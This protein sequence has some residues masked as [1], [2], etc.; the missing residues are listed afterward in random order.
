MVERCGMRGM[1]DQ[2]QTRKLVRRNKAPRLR[3]VA[4]L[5]G[6]QLPVIRAGDDDPVT[7]GGGAGV[8]V[9]VRAERGRI[10]GVPD[11]AVILRRG[12][13]RDRGGAEYI[14]ELPVVGVVGGLAAD[15]AHH[16]IARGI[17]RDGKVRA[18]DVCRVEVRQGSVFVGFD[19]PGSRVR[20][21]QNFTRIP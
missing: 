5:E 11:V 7:V 4:G 21:S 12:P 17:I 19:D 8:A 2:L 1:S 13:H 9:P 15:V 20:V 10:A 16:R 3:A 6:V 14:P 18:G